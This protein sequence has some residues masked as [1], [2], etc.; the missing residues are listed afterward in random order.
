MT[1]S[2]PLIARTLRIGSERAQTPNFL[3]DSL[4]FLEIIRLIRSPALLM[5]NTR[6]KSKIRALVFRI[7]SRFYDALESIGVATVDMTNEHPNQDA[8]FS[9]PLNLYAHLN[10]PFSL[11]TLEAQPHLT[12]DEAAHRRSAD[13][14]LVGLVQHVACIDL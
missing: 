9:F 13:E 10:F 3:P 1:R 14:G 12:E 11:M 5:K 8:V 6:S 4:N 7:N 2:K